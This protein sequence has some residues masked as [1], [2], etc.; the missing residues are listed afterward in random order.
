MKLHYSSTSIP[1]LC[2]AKV[3]D[4]SYFRFGKNTIAIACDSSGSIGELEKDAFRATSAEAGVNMVEVPLKEILCVGAK[5][6]AVYLDFCYA[7]NSA[8]EGFLASVHREL[9]SVGADVPV[10]VHFGTYE[11]PKYSALGLTILASAEESTLRIGTSEPGDLVYVIGL[12]LNKNYFP[13]QTRTETIAKILELDYVHEV[14][15]CGSHGILYEADELA[16]TNG[17]TFREGDCELLNQQNDR[18]CGAA[19]VALVTV[20]AD[21]KEDF[22]ALSLP[23]ERNL[24]GTLCGEKA[25]AP[26]AEL[27]LPAEDAEICVTP[28]GSIHFPDGYVI[29]DAAAV[30]Y[31]QGEQAEDVPV[32]GGVEAVSLGLAE[33]ALQRLDEQGSAPFLLIND[34]NFGME[35]LGRRTIAAIRE[36]LLRRDPA[37]D[38]R[39]QFTGSTED[40]FPTGQSGFA[41]HVFGLHRE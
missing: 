21:R 6:L 13:L 1:G 37:I 11:A 10:F 35:P 9:Q 2:S 18:S 29:S 27:P 7:K 16:K 3:R 22:E 36:M 8:T 40:N 28:D 32:E 4:L 15:P 38:L 24:Y 39:A 41:V 25:A 23:R 34:L 33:T 17:L 19:A 26:Q 20:P 5:P 14:L 30:S 12:P 31:G